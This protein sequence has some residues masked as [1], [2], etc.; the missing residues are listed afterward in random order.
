M[1]IH[2]RPG[3]AGAGLLALLL[4]VPALHA[5]ESSDRLAG[6]G[7]LL[8]GIGD[9]LTHGTMDASNN[10]TNTLNA[11]WQRV[12]DA[13]AVNRTVRFSQPLFD[14]QQQRLSPWR[15]PSNL[16]VDGA[17]LFSADGLEYYKRVGAE[18]SYVD[19]DYLCDVDRPAQ[20]DD[21]YDKVLFPLNRL[22]AQDVSQIDGVVTLLERNA[23]R[24]GNGPSALLFWL[25]NNDS[26]LAALGSGGLNPTY[27]PL[28][29]PQVRG[30][31]DPLLRLVGQVA[32]NQGL[33][34]FA[35]YTAQA[36]ERN[37]TEVGDFEAQL[38]H[39][40]SRIAAV[41][42]GAGKDV[43]V[44]TLPY[45]S[46]VGYLM[47]STDLTFYLQQLDPAYRLP[48]S[49]TPVLEDQPFSGD[50]VSL[51]T[52]GMMYALLSTGSSIAKVNSVLEVGGVQ[53][54]G[55]VMSAAESQTIRDRIDAYNAVIAQAVSARGEGFHLVDIGGFINSVFA[56]ESP[57][58]VGGQ[59]LQR[60]WSRGD[61]FS[62]DGVHPGYTAQALIANELLP[63][64]DA[65][66]GGSSPAVD[67]EAVYA[68][69]PY[70]DRDDD[71]WVP[72]PDS[73]A[74]GLGELLFLFTDPDDADPAVGAQLP[75]DVWQ[76]ISD[77]LLEELLG[78][79][80]IRAAAEREGL[81]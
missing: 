47:D 20:L 55:L 51:L 26:S 40:L 24:Q 33:V 25:G 3:F 60:N 71:G 2:D 48:P 58:V 1:R 13:L 65:V 5:Q 75:D 46:A 30:E 15:L 8:V 37:L 64:M 7:L 45:Y 80:A 22:A 76:Q 79:P 35:P 69:D 72:G 54:D 70:V 34:S 78:V 57:V 44:L 19:D 16:G 28:P 66:L 18:L 50:R 49:F 12:A 39:L 53:A 56:G 9:S 29:F 42:D 41:P 14:D 11:Y 10:A 31:L 36:I 63:V 77:A 6:E 21:K 74:S 62:L 32:E 52:F 27:M 67:L 4:S 17:D 81:L 68:V 38:G 59:S 23:A 61:A 43:F 73:P